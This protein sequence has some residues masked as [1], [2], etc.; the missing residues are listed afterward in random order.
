MA[1]SKGTP[2]IDTGTE[3]GAENTEGHLPQDVDLYEML[4]A[5]HPDCLVLVIEGKIA[6]AS[7]RCLELTG[8]TA[9]EVVGMSPTD[10]L[11]PEDR[12]RSTM[13]IDDLLNGGREHPSV[14]TL[15]RKNGDTVTIDANARRILYDGK[16]ALISVLRDITEREEAEDSLRQSEERYR[17]LLELAPYGL[18]IIDEE[19]TIES[20]NART[21]ELFGYDRTELAGKP[22]TMLIPERFRQRHLEHSR[23]YM[24]A[25]YAREI[26]FEEGFFGLRK[27]GSEF[28]I[29]A[30]LD[31]LQTESGLRVIGA[32]RDI[33]ERHA[34][35]Q[36]LRQSEA[37]FSTAFHDNPIPAAITSAEDDKLID[38]N[39]AL[40]AMASLRRSEA[41]GH[42]SVEL[43]ILLDSEVNQQMA[44]AIR[45]QG[46]FRDLSARFKKKNGDVLDLLISSTQIDLNGDPCLLTTLVDITEQ[47][48]MEGELQEMRDDLE[49][50][51]E[52]RMSGENPYKLTFREYTVLHLIAAGKADKEIA[53]ELAISI[54]TVHRHVSKILAKMDSPSRTEA[55]TRALREALLD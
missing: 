11:I 18:V 49:S 9:E 55:G 54:Y 22:L 44:A 23:A 37:R 52:R 25:P 38:V 36:E 29:E 50:K 8:Y 21:E 1:E 3:A 28:P 48:R 20:V 12:T 53:V 5:E 43:G 16:A 41:I 27:D 15:L 17:R 31:S 33:S 13:R 14:Y 45:D 39:D 35:V 34:A 47:K 32:I 10:L 46:A 19:G 40:L 4:F 24:A 6:L 7:D 42:S 26:G 30:S 51:V 2:P